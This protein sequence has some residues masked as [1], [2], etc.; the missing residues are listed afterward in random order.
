MAVWVHRST[1]T[2]GVYKPFI[3]RYFKCYTILIGIVYAKTFSFL[4]GEFLPI[5]NQF[6]N[7]AFFKLLNKLT[8]FNVNFFLETGRL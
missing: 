3:T 5:F 7:F 4:T 2:A 8:D 6:W 1:L